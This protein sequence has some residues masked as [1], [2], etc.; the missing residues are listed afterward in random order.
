MTQENQK[1]S[2]IFR[3]GREVLPR[4]ANVIEKNEP[5]LQALCDELERRVRSGGSLLVFGSGHSSIFPMELYHRAGGASFVIPVVNEFLTPLA[6][7]PVVRQLERTLSIS[8]IALARVRP[9]AGDMLW[10]SS[11]SGINAAAIEVALEAKKMGIYTVSFSSFAH[12]Q[13]VPSRHSSGRRLMD[14]TDLAID[15][16]GVKGDAVVNLT[17][18]LQAGPFSTLS[19]VF[20]GHSV[21][22]EVCDRLEKSGHACV[23]TSVNTP[24]GEENNRK[25]EAKARE[26]D[27]LL[28]E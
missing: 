10:L 27:I 9:M 28:R 15:L 14:V 2:G 24:E 4:L 18:R 8:K 12:S 3:Y 7:P 22:V 1:N 21:L 25:I 17:D 19:S 6:G 23:Y 26:R 16:G 20:L 5:A 11:Q 13:S